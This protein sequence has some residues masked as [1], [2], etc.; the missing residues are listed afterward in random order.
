MQG[1]SFGGVFRNIFGSEEPPDKILEV[2]PDLYTSRHI[3]VRED[4]LIMYLPLN[5]PS[6]KEKQLYEIVLHR[7]ASETHNVAYSLFRSCDQAE[8]EIRFWT[9]KNR[10][11][12]IIDVAKEMCSVH[13]LQK[14]C[15]VLIK[16]PNWTLAHIAAHFSLYDSFN[17]PK[18]N[19]F[20]NSTDEDSGMS[21]LQVAILSKNLKTVQMLVDAKCSLE[22]LDHNNNSVF[23]YAASTTKEIIY[24]LTQ[25]TPSAC[26]NSR[27]KDGYTPL[28]K[29]CLSDK[30]ECVRALLKAGAD[31]N[32][33]AT[34]SDEENNEPSYL[35]NFVQQNKDNQLNQE[36]M[37][38]GGTP[39]H[40]AC[41]KTVIETLID[42]NC[43]INSGNF[44]KRTALHIMVLRN[45][46]DCAVALLS[47]GADP[48][49]ADEEGNRPLHFA[50]KA[51][52]ISLIQCLVIFGADLD[53]MNNAGETARHLVDSKALYYLAAVGARR[54]LP[55]TANCNPGCIN[56]DTFEGIPPEPVI[57]PTNRH[58]LNQMLMV[59]SM[60]IAAEKYKTGNVPRKGR[61][62]C[63]DGGGIRGLVLVQCL[64]ELENI[65]GKPIVHCFDWIA[66][67]STGGI[68]SLA[69]T[70]GKT[71]KECLC[72][73]FKLKEVTFVGK[74]PYP[75]ENLEN[76]LKE[77]FGEDTVMSDLKFPKVMVTGVLAD[78][79]PAEL[80]LFRNY[81]S[82]SQLLDVKHDSPYELPPPPKEQYVWEVGRA[83]GAA[84]TYFRAHGRYLDGGLIA[85]NP[86]LDAMT[87][88]LEHTLALKA[89]GREEE[90][91][92]ISVV[93][94]IGTG[95]IPVTEIKNIDVYRP[96]GI[97]DSA[98]VFMGFQA[99]SQLLVDQATSSD[100]RVVDRARAW[101]ASIGVPYFRFCPQMSEDFN[102]DEKDDQK[103]CQ[104]LWETK[105]YMRKNVATMKELSDIINK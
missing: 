75:S 18:I 52:H 72:L 88:I 4:G 81:E 73:Y 30:P 24:V 79:K 57:G 37:K 86:T 70:S 90:A 78:R 34:K 36:D 11:S 104:L 60:E 20:L 25:G 98:K 87:E 56:D 27:N 41:S 94:S 80:H 10:L 7:P 54:C 13:G 61:L 77:T 83:T 82:A 92:P 22:H 48:D 63:L 3:H 85:N 93:V 105:V 29:A 43:S 62:L 26:L 51:G 14:I 39:L 97:F 71:M 38:Y 16:N 15:D 5:N 35:V 1:F 96:E 76:V 9:L 89:V 32:K 68:L 103:L 46:L 64:L 84:P 58:V 47:H 17:N 101:C 28:H 2:K 21:P 95:I 40:W 50:A 69:I 45:R 99:L 19:T 91:A 100:G 31:V 42:M 33:T 65:F 102:M 44:Q 6:K 49:L 55:G 12:D 66:G 74:R 8:A 59:A 23:H 67:T 53:L